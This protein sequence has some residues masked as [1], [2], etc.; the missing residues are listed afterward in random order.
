M[1]CTGESVITCFGA[2]QEG[3]SKRR[4]GHR[5]RRGFGR[6]ISYEV[7][8]RFI[9]PGWTGV[10][11]DVGPTPGFPYYFPSYGTPPQVAAAA[12]VTLPPAYHEAGQVVLVRTA[13]NV[14]TAYTANASGYGYPGQSG[15]G[16][17]SWTAGGSAGAAVNT[18]VSV[19]FWKG[20]VSSFDV[21][22]LVYECT[23]SADESE[24]DFAIDLYVCTAAVVNAGRPSADGAH[25][26]S[27][28]DTGNRYEQHH[29]YAGLSRGAGAV[30]KG[31][32][33]PV[34]QRGEWEFFRAHQEGATS[35]EYED[36]TKFERLAMGRE[37][38]DRTAWVMDRCADNEAMR[39]WRRMVVR[40]VAEGLDSSETVYG[41]NAD[42]E[43]VVEAAGSLLRW[44]T[45]PAGA[46]G[47]YGGNF[48]YFWRGQQGQ[49]P[50]LMAESYEP[51][52]RAS[53]L[54]SVELGAT[55]MVWRWQVVAEKW[56]P[57]VVT[58]DPATWPKYFEG[59]VRQ[60]VSLE[61]E[62][63]LEELFGDVVMPPWPGA[64]GPLGGGRGV[65]FDTVAAVT[66]PASPI[67]TPQRDP[68][69]VVSEA[70]HRLQGPTY[71][72]R[73]VHCNGAATSCST[74]T[75]APGTEVEY[76]AT[77]AHVGQ[78]TLVQDSCRCAP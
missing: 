19:G 5:V 52:I 16:V 33:V 13:E 77:L 25:F 21:G 12:G 39:R 47:T 26:R 70:R 35:V 41:V 63:T 48:P 57:Q 2:C 15:A 17:I 36:R 78:T 8:G 43:V 28:W 3:G 18:W 27:I 14:A 31:Y 20:G 76:A 29:V 71:C 34:F 53:R 75:V 54:T 40:S 46:Y 6:L 11:P 58:G 10:S 37:L 68:R 42:G 24:D 7:A 65:E 74:V 9:R 32:V 38:F 61:D 45:A 72:E 4:V 55:G 50:T 73:V 49:F 30:A 66:V 67:Q 60:E 22:D 62:Y 23:P 51:R 64:Y 56:V 1:S 69:L 44:G 59:E